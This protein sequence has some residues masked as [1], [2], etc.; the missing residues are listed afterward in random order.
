MILFWRGWGIAVFVVWM[1]WI[2]AAIWIGLAYGGPQFQAAAGSLDWM[3][4]ISC[5]LTAAS[6]FGI[7]RYRQ[8]HPRTL[9]DPETGRVA[10]QAHADEF[11]FIRL[12]FW[13]HALLLLAVVMGIKGFLT[14]G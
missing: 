4:G 14:N 5:V 1:V 9:V 11:M 3:I 8:S 6:V 7:D 2:V 10:Q 12:H 13:P